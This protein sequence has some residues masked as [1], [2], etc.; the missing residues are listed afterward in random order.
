MCLL[1]FRHCA[2]TSSDTQNNL[3]VVPVECKPCPPGTW[4]TCQSKPSCRWVIPT[5]P[6][7][8]ALGEDIHVFP[9][10]PGQPPNTPTTLEHCL[11]SP[12]AVGNCYPCRSVS[13]CMTCPYH[14]IGTSNQA[15]I[16]T[17]IAWRCPGRSCKERGGMPAP[18]A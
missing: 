8:R 9:G 6:D 10:G 18:D 11:T 3:Q 1:V 15:E 14:F 7:D 17:T 12:A 5:K 16:D 4:N 13:K 2:E